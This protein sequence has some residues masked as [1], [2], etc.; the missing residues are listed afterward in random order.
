MNM[1]KRFLPEYDVSEMTKAE[2]G[3]I[4]TRF[5]IGRDLK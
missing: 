1:V 4:L 2:A 3:A 5:F